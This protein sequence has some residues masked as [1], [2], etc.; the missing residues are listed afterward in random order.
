[1]VDTE[2]ISLLKAAVKVKKHDTSEESDG[3]DT[4][5]VTMTS[6]KGMLRVGV[7]E[8]KLMMKLKTTDDIVKHNFPL[9]Q[10]VLLE[11]SAIKVKSKPENATK[12]EPITLDEAAD[13]EGQE[14]KKK[15]K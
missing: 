9:N 1:M 12:T 2:K 13:K 6:I 3:T 10:D 5:T 8:A 14:E 4:Y 15:K 7:G 11:I